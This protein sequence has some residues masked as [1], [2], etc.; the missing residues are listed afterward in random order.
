M[1]RL[2]HITGIVTFLL[3]AGISVSYGQNYFRVIEEIPHLPMLDPASVAS[4]EPGM[5]IFSTTDAKPMIYNGDSWTRLTETGNAEFT[6]S[7][8]L[9]TGISEQITLTGKRKGKCDV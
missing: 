2:L 4:P 3:F 1:K 7:P 5:L 6:E 9:S 8:G